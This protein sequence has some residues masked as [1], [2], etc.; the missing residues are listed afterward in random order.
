MAHSV[1]HTQIGEAPF[2]YLLEMHRDEQK[3]V[4][5]ACNYAL[6]HGG[7]VCVKDATGRVVYGTDPAELNRA[8]AQGINQYFARAA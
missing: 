8:I 7:Y 6:D 4:R 5:R 3:A 2:W 1:H